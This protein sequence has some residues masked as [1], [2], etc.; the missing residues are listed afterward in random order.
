[1][2]TIVIKE[3]GVFRKK[4]FKAQARKMWEHFFK[5]AVPGSDLAHWEVD[6]N[7][8]TILLSSRNSSV[9]ETDSDW[10]PPAPV[11]IV[12]NGIAELLNA[13]PDAWDE[14][15]TE[16]LEWVTLGIM[17]SFKSASVSKRFKQ[18]LK[19]N[20]LDCFAIVTSPF[21]EGLIEN[22]LALVWS[23]NDCLTV[24]KIKARQKAAAKYDTRR[25]VKKKP[26]RKRK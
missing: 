17:Q 12:V 3:R 18:Y 15:G 2:K 21:D 14:L 23:K 25:P 20:Q 24:K 6:P 22:D 11:I 8:A 5:T 1:M 16:F 9:S 4:P 26:R 10:D 19:S 7:S 13:D